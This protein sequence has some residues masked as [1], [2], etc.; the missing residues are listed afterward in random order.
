MA[1]NS[2]SFSAVAF[3]MDGLIFDT[4][5]ISRHALMKTAADFDI[6]IDDQYYQG[7][8]GNSQAVCEQLLYS[9][10]GEA[11]DVPAFRENWWNCRM[12]LVEDQGVNFKV[13]FHELF[14]F[15]ETTGLPLALVT[16][17]S[18]SEVLRNFRGETYPDRFDTIV[19]WDRGLAPKPAPDKYLAA[20]GDLEVRPETMLVLED[21]NT[22]MQAAIN[23]GCQAVMVPDLVQPHESIHK[24]AAKILPDLIAVRRWLE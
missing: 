21:S 15:L 16:T 6:E 7:F 5:S 13:G 24:Q 22:G 18:H 23:A 10:F 14:A 11:F 8:I 9:R 19:T 20:A 2:W 12:Q 4:E 17:S 1:M 3:D